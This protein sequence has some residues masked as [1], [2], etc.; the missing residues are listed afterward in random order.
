MVKKIK[1]VELNQPVAAPDVEPEPVEAPSEPIPMQLDTPPIETP[2]IE[3]P[4]VEVKP[5]KEKQPRKPRAP[6]QP[7]VKEALPPTPEE[8]ASDGDSINTEEAIAVITEH[9]KKKKQ[10][11]PPP[12][13]PAPEP[14]KEERAECPDC[15]KK[16]SAK[17]LK[18][19]HAK[20]CK[21]N[22]PPPVKQPP[23]AQQ[24]MV[25]EQPKPSLHEL[26][27]AEKI[28]RQGARRQK[29][30]ALLTEAFHNNL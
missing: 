28:M 21:A 26:I 12:P 25:A 23:V 29:F 24:Q 19:S 4:Q 6:K 22:N 5:A 17:A 8:P 20:N 15:H 16:M 27:Q 11:E 30:Q 13:T 14:I 1:V 9:R 18:Y 3:T 7:K 10:P 2:P